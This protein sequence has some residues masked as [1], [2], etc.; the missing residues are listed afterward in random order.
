MVAG[1]AA[2]RRAAAQLGDR[3]DDR[4]GGARRRGARGRAVALRPGEHG[5]RTAGCCSRCRSPACSPRWRSGATARATRSCSSSPAGLATLAIPVIAAAQVLL[6]I[7]GE[8]GLLP[9]FWELVALAAGCGLIAY[10]AVDR[11]PG[12]AWLGVAHLLAFV[13]V[14]NAA[15]EA[16]LLWWPLILLALGGGV[17]AAGL[18]PRRPLPPEPAGY[19]VDRPLASRADDEASGPARIASRAAW[20]TATSSGSPRRTCARAPRW[21]ASCGRAAIDGLRRRCG[22]GRSTT[23]PASGRRSGTSSR[24]AGEHGEVLADASMPGASWF[25]GT[26]LNYAERLFRGKPGD[27]VAIRHASETAPARRAGRGTSCARRPPRSA[28]AWRRAASAAATA[29]PPTCRTCPRRSPR[30]WPPRRSARSGRRRAP[31]FGRRS[32]DRPLRA[33]RAEGAAGGRRL[34]LRRQGLRPR[35]RPSRRSPTR[36][37]RRLVTLGYLDGTR[38]GGRLPAATAPLEFERGPVRP[39]ALGPLLARHDRAAQGDRPGPGRDPAR[40]PQEDVPAP[41]RAGRATASS[42]SRRRAG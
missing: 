42:G 18:R 22:S 4:R 2:Y 15:A 31:E 33:D 11:V 27:R 16:T 25:P 12:A 36:S 7:G 32:V 35:A 5:R 28:R 10:G 14:V 40:A 20:R 1:V 9:A 26:T 37:A 3:D 29:S 21:R 24:S 8:D 19:S 39:P 34:P 38:L 41:R 6:P 30:S 23:S 17:M 13:I